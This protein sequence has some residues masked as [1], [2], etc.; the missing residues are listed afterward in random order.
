[1]LFKHAQVLDAGGGAGGLREGFGLGSIAHPRILAS[2]LGDTDEVG[3]LF[4]DF[5]ENAEA[6][7]ADIR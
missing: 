2:S 5:A 3:K 7:Y 6:Y 1:V 4:K